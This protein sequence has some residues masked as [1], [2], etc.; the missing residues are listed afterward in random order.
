MN[1]VRLENLSREA[2]LGPWAELELKMI[3][4]RRAEFSWG[5]CALHGPELQQKSAGK[6]QAQSCACGKGH[7]VPVLG[8]RRTGRLLWTTS[9]GAGIRQHTLSLLLRWVCGESPG[10]LLT[11]LQLLSFA[12]QDHHYLRQFGHL[13]LPWGEKL[14]WS[15]GLSGLSQALWLLFTLLSSL[16][17][18]WYRF[19]LEP[20]SPAI[21]SFILHSTASS[22]LHV[23]VLFS[24][25]WV[26]LLSFPCKG[27]CSWDAIR[28]HSLLLP[29]NVVQRP[30][31]RNCSVCTA[32]E[33]AQDLHTLSCSTLSGRWR[34]SLFCSCKMKGW[35]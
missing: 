15:T 20:V 24:L 10:T 11:S 6:M 21:Y 1:T 4:G 30:P 2:Q 13:N 7:E 12:C 34:L 23:P 14:L 31:V 28:P 26:W 33:L 35:I 19:C 22:T 27:K 17:P 16:W 32:G 18:P 29:L 8:T 9:W 5:L 25:S 3:Y